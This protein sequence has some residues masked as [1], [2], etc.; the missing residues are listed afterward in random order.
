MN[1]YERK[2]KSIEDVKGFFDYLVNEH[3]LSFHPDSDFNEYIKSDGSQL[4]SQ[5]ECQY[6]NEKMDE[7]FTICEKEGCDIY[8]IGIKALK[9]K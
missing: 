4:F 8:T 9:V 5:K 3:S 6:Y 1:L 2:I 7:S